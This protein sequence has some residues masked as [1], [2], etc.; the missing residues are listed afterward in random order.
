VDKLKNVC[1]IEIEFTRNSL[2]RGRE[3]F[4]TELEI[5]PVRKGIAAAHPE[6]E[7]GSQQRNKEIHGSNV[8]MQAKYYRF[9]TITF[10]LLAAMLAGCGSKI[11]T[12][13]LQPNYNELKW[14]VEEFTVKTGAQVKL[15]MD[16]IA[17]GLTNVMSHNA[18]I[19]ARRDT[20]EARDTLIEEVGK[21]ATEVGEAKEFFPE[22]HPGIILRTPLA[23]PGQKTEIIFTAPAPGDYPYIC[24]F[25]GHWKTMRGVMHVVE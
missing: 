23:A 1:H 7:R 3:T 24:T 12:V 18:V 4:S 5:D 11:Q 20:K 9:L 2:E 16:N 14:Q 13:F 25:A 21:A 17:S 10:V 19:L 6:E 8:I 15:V 22:N